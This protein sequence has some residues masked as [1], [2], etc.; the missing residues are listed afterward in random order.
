MK[1]SQFKVSWD[2]GGEVGIPTANEE[3]LKYIRKLETRKNS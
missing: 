2:K 1:I 3:Y